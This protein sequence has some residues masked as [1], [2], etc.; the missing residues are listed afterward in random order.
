MARSGQL[1]CCWRRGQGRAAGQGKTGQGELRFCGDG[2]SRLGMCRIFESPNATR[3]A[4]LPR[5]ET[6]L[7]QERGIAEYMQLEVGMLKT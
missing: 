6:L 3:R 7:S 2:V 4:R 1:F 5:T